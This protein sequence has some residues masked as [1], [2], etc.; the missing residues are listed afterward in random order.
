MHLQRE[1]PCIETV[2]KGRTDSEG[3]GFSLCTAPLIWACASNFRWSLEKVQWSLEN[4]WRQA[5]SVE[6]WRTSGWVWETPGGIPEILV[7]FH[8]LDR[9]KYKCWI[10]NP[11]LW[12]LGAAWLSKYLHI[13][14]SSCVSYLPS[15]DFTCLLRLVAFSYI[16]CI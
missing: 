7:E 13:F 4:F 14:V 15:V 3:F 9:D 5:T 10:L 6:C 1:Y 8:L 12:S 11:S 2:H 16:S